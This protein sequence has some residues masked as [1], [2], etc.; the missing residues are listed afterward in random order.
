MA[1]FDE[2]K[3]A[4]DNGISG[5]RNGATAVLGS[6]IT[7]NFLKDANHDFMAT[8]ISSLATN[9]PLE[10]QKMLQD[11]AVQNEIGNAGTIEKLNDYVANSM[12]KQSEKAAVMD[13]GAALRKMNSNE[14]DELLSGR[15]NL[16]QVT[17][18][19]EKNKSLTEG[20][21]DMLLGIYGIRSTY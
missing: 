10:A 13:L 20:S 18:F 1:K 15:A 2:V 8:Y 19:I 17:S 4:Y 11:V 6:E 21:K 14:A 3:L 7:E 12:K 16:N 9:N 5:L